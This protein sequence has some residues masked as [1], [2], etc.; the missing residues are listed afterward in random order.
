MTEIWKQIPGYEGYY[1]VSSKG[2]IRS[3]DRIVKGRWGQPFPLK[4]KLKDTC[5]DKYGYLHVSLCSNNKRF[6]P[7]VHRLV[8]LAFIPNPSNKPC[9]DHVDGNKLNNNVE[10]LRWCTVLESNRN[11]VTIQRHREIVYTEERNRHVSEGLKGHF[12]SEETK[13]KIS[14]SRKQYYKKVKENDRSK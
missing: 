9:I 13:R 7:T 12:V 5:L 1:E 4:G 10:N 14:N 6:Y 11:P 2:R 3:M 8:A